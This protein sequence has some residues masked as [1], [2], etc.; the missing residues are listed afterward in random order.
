MAH[1]HYSPAPS[2]SQILLTTLRRR[3]R[4]TKFLI[5]FFLIVLLLRFEWAYFGPRM[6][7]LAYDFTAPDDDSLPIRLAAA[8][9][10]YQ[11]ALRQRKELIHRVGP[12]KSEIAAFPRDLKLYTLWDFFIPAFRCPHLVERIGA[13]GVGGKWI[14]GLDRIADKNDCIVY[15]FGSSWESSFEAELLKRTK[16]CKIYGYHYDSKKFGPEVR[17][18]DKLK[19]R[20]EFTK[21]GLASRDEPPNYRSL[22]SIM[23]ENGEEIMAGTGD[24]V[25]SDLTFLFSLLSGSL[26][27]TFVDVIKIDI[28]GWEFAALLPLF[29]GYAELP[30][31]FGQLQLEIHV[32]DMEFDKILHWWEALENA[33]LRPFYAEPNLVYVNINRGTLP[34]IAEYSFLN[35]RGNSAFISNSPGGRGSGIISR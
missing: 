30:L 18:I 35:I 20:S 29:E 32:G 15:S 25:F 28:E 21:Y 31:P 4:L 26:G 27:H 13:L 9:E 3:P 12:D 22:T 8:E 14:C 1:L 19:W 34:D 23:H 10:V 24:I 16:Y 17:S 7:Y 6:S 11:Q 5:S 2:L 33:G